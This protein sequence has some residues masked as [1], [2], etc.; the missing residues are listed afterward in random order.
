MSIFLGISSIDCD[1]T[2][3]FIKDGEIVYAAQEERFT[4]KK[5][6]SGFPYKTIEDGLRYLGISTKDIAA[7]GYGWYKPDVEK[8]LY[9]KSGWLSVRQSLK[10]KTGLGTAMRHSLNVI[11]RGWFINPPDYNKSYKLL[12]KGLEDIGYKGPV[13]FFHHQ[14]CHIA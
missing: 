11:R 2:A 3:T 6:Q 9:C 5:Q 10:F 4:R 1:V 13:E 14:L 12:V 7:V 8:K